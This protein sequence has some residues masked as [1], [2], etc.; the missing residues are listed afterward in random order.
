MVLPPG[1]VV[2]ENHKVTVTQILCGTFRQTISR[3]AEGESR[4]PGLPESV[5]IFL[6]LGPV[7]QL[8]RHC[9]IQG[10]DGATVRTTYIR[11]RLGRLPT[12]LAIAGHAVPIDI[13]TRAALDL[14][15]NGKAMPT[16]NVPPDLVSRRRGTSGP[17][18]EDGL[19]G[20]SVRRRA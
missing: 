19:T 8:V 9:R 11:F 13:P 1:I 17:R 16:V 5:T 18:N 4:Q 14:H 12:I 6:A 2:R 7:Q 10:I 15:S 3:A 20:E